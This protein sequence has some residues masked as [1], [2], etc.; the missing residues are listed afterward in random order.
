M[1]QVTTGATNTEFTETRIIINPPAGIVYVSSVD[2]L[3]SVTYSINF[4]TGEIKFHIS[5][6]FKKDKRLKIDLMIN[7][8][9]KI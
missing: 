3:G 7:D 5:V 2:P 8:F 9:Y 1:I 6:N 4:K